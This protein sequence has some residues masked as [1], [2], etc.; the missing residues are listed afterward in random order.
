MIGLKLARQALQLPFGDRDIVAVIGA[1]QLRLHS[2]TL[3]LRQMI[4]HVPQFVDLTALEE[5]RRAEGSEPAPGENG[6]SS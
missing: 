4:E 2:R 6:G 5:R 3:A 1:L